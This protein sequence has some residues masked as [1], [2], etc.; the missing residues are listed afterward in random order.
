MKLS[1]A[2]AIALL[3]AACDA[4]QVKAPEVK[5]PDVA[6]ARSLLLPA[7][8]S[9]HVNA[10]A[11]DQLMTPGTD[12]GVLPARGVVVHTWG[13]AGD[14]LIVVDRDARTLHLV[15]NTIHQKDNDYTRSLAPSPFGRVIATA[16][17]AWH[18]TGAGPMPS[19][20]DIREDLIVLDGEEAFYLSGHPISTLVGGEPTGRPAAARAMAAIYSAAR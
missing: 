18:E 10:V 2:L 11:R 9:H 19:A 15:E 5:T 14:T 17:D 6:V 20:T 12:P 8:G 4:G 7:P 1:S 13:L 3:V 16:F